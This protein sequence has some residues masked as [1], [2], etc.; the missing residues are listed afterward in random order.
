MGHAVHRL[1]LLVPLGIIGCLPVE[2]AVAE[3]R[4]DWLRDA[5]WGVMT[6]YLADWIARRE[7]TEMSVPRWNE[8]IDNFDVERLA[9]QLESIGA[10]YYLITIGQNSGYHLAP[11]ETYDRLVGIKP[12]K[13]A[14]RDL[15]TELSVVLGERGIPLMVYLP[16]GAPGG[17]RTAREALDWRRGPYPNRD[18]Q[19]KWE[20][21]I[22]EW[23]T[24]WGDRV[25]G[26][27]FDG[28]YW[29]NTMYRHPEPPNFASFAAAARAGN[30]ESIVAFNP[31][32]YARILSITPHEDYT[33][34]E[35]NDP[36]RIEYKR[37]EDG[38][39]DGTQLHVLSYL[40]ETW[41]RG[42]PRF[43]TDQFV[44]WSRT[45]WANEGAVTWDVPIQTGGY[46]ALPYLEQLRAVGDAAR[47]R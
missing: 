40:G 7:R 28:C 29:P 9:N 10:G 45:V 23:S 4:A 27:W 31:G 12:S 11:N 34:G 14:R 41:G 46:I 35:I 16:A 17:D 37:I 15:I 13:C 33:A 47:R 21:V 39:R 3:H 32:V 26:W 22:R 38:R 36:A 18:F 2:Q 44:D 19:L 30:P 25:A 8:M 42:E 43:T 6:H 20:Q 24:R 5:K 1:L